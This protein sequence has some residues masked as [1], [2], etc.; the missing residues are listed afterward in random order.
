MLKNFGANIFQE[1]STTTIEAEPKLIGQNINIP[2][3]ISSAAYFI[4]AGLIVPGSSLLIK[5]V[6]INPT[7]DGIIKSAKTWVVKSP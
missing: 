2:G 4:V 6:G 5:N 7:R 1:G 3:D